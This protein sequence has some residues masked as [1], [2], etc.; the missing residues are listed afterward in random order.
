MCSY[1]SVAHETSLTGKDRFPKRAFRPGGRT[2][3]QKHVSKE[4]ILSLA[5][6]KHGRDVP[7]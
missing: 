3:K 2:E 1:E 6:S 7:I 5:L 4:N